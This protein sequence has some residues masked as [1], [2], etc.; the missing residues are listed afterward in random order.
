[1]AST[2]EK[3]SEL[4]AEAKQD[5]TVV[6][7]GTG[8]KCLE[9]QQHLVEARGKTQKEQLET[10]GCQKRWATKVGRLVRTRHEAKATRTWGVK[11]VSPQ[12]TSLVRSVLRRKVSRLM[13]SSI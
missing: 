11:V 10:E 13:S 2:Q 12:L 7:G 5:E 1:M 3:R 9:A 8:G 4:D 6:L